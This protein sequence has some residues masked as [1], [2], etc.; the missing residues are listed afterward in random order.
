MSFH[1]RIRFGEGRVFQLR[2]ELTDIAPAMWRRLAV[3]ERASLRELHEVIESAI[4]CESGLGYAFH[5]DGV[6]YLDAVDEPPP[7][8]ESDATSL[9]SLALHPGARFVHVAETHGEPWCHAVTLELAIPRLVG[10]RLPVCLAGGRAA[11]PEDC[12]GPRA[13]RD[14]L[15][16]LDDPTD[17]RAAELRTWLPEH[18]DPEYANVTAIN[19]SLAK[20]RKQRP[21]A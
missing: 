1:S 12:G 6:R 14:L 20:V 8:R 9:E 10:Q 15:A 3:S 4:G 11:P 7:G 18:F 19:A 16:A 13:Y 17:P 5:I 2:V 21:A